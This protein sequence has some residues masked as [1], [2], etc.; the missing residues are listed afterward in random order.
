MARLGIIMKKEA[1]KRPNIIKRIVII[2]FAVVFFFIAIYLMG[3]TN[4]LSGGKD[5][6]EKKLE[7]ER[8]KTEE[9]EHIYNSEQDDEYKIDIARD[10]GYAFPDEQV[11]YS[12]LPK[13]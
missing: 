8:I 4:Q 7:E 2:S 1:V 13:S 6:L 9:L 5:E 3:L 12:S 11:Y 10:H